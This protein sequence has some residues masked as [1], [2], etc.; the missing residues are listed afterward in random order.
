MGKTVRDEGRKE[1][2]ARAPSHLERVVGKA[3]ES[4]LELVIQFGMEAFQEMLEEDLERLCGPRHARV[5]DR[6]AYRHGHEPSRLG[7]GGRPPEALTTL[8]R[9]S[10]CRVSW[11]LRRCHA[12][13]FR[14]PTQV[15][16]DA[17]GRA[18]A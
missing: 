16:G 2:E 8:R 5:D 17:A 10:N 1:G 13:H 14:R 6:Q 7:V 12:P 4:L 15:D 11:L 3:R 18:A 9:A